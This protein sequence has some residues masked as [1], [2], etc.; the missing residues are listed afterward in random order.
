MCVCVCVSCARVCVHV[1]LV[2]AF[3]LDVC[4]HICLVCLCSLSMWSVGRLCVSV[5]IYVVIR[6]CV[7]C[8][9]DFILWGWAWLASLGTGGVRA[10]YRRGRVS[11]WK[12]VRH[13]CKIDRFSAHTFVS[14]I[15]CLCGVQRVVFVVRDVLSLR[16]AM[17]LLLFAL[18][19]RRVQCA[20]WSLL[21][22]CCPQIVIAILMSFR[23]WWQVLILGYGRGTGR[24][25]A[26][27]A[28]FSLNIS[29]QS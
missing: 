25:R 14:V 22:Q 24:V 3:L 13:F 16:F 21:C 17:F 27:S 4:R 2:V 12:F 1:D 7:R 26:E 6:W 18:C 19:C 9:C 10:G 8:N 11:G 15:C 28:L 29:L 5:R 20:C 23:A